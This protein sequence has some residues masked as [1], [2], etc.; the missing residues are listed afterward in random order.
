MQLTDK[1]S[2][3]DSVKKLFGTDNVS[4]DD[5]LIVNSYHSLT[6]LSPIDELPFQFGRVEGDFIC[7]DTGLKSFK[8]FP[9]FIGGSLI[10]RTNQISNFDDFPEFID[11][12]IDLYENKL[13]KLYNLPKNHKYS[14]NLNCN[15]IASLEGLPEKI[16]GTL[17]IMSNQLT[18]LK[19]TLKEVNN[20]ECSYNK[21]TSLEGMPRVL[22]CFDCA[23]N[24]LISLKYM[25]DN[26]KEVKAYNN[27]LTHFDKLPSSIKSILCYNNLL[28]DLS[29]LNHLIL[30]DVI[31]S[32][33]QITQINTFKTQCG[34]L[35]LSYNPIENVATENRQIDNLIVRDTLIQTIDGEKINAGNHGLVFSHIKRIKN[36]HKISA[37]YIELV[38]TPLTDELIEDILNVFS[39]EENKDKALIIDQRAQRLI[40]YNENTLH[41][42]QDN[43]KDDPLI[44]AY[45][46]KKRLDSSLITQIEKK[47][48]K[49]I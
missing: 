41:L 16:G 31:A 36:I 15:Q 22:N 45:L 46:E 24:E 38:N 12:D 48:I 23:H 34:L 29:E 8:G 25:D 17:K 21:I 32:N 20:L 39:M 14:L 42:T 9:K 7:K 49:K 5:N 2:I 30:K 10:V 3:Q 27:K 37:S 4:I 26:I 35:D 43:V 6:L 11:G 33:N 1:K 19:G 40:R 28:T 18:H 44:Q 13:T 47:S